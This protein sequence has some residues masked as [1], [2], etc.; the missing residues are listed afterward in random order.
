MIGKNKRKYLDQFRSN[1][2][3]D[4]IYQG[5]L[6]TYDGEDK[7]RK[8]AII[9]L[10]MI[11]LAA[12]ALTVISG[13]LKGAGNT[14]TFYIV[15]PYI[16][17]VGA[18]GFLIYALLSLLTGGNP[19]RE[20]VFMNSYGKVH[21]RAMVTVVSAGVGLM[22]SILYIVGHG[23][24]NKLAATF[25]YILIRVAVICLAL[26]VDKEHR[27]IKYADFSGIDKKTGI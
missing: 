19:I 8:K 5:K 7:D 4:I 3:G 21:Q 17:E 16:V 26:F 14:N 22:G 11:G 18:Q 2:S 15:I 27:K 12:F 20:Y 23:F 6:Y 10:L 24:E 1:L 25:M 13:T 9:R